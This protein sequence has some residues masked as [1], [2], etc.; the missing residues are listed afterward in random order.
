MEQDEEDGVIGCS[1][2]GR[3]FS[4]RLRLARLLLILPPAN[5]PL[6]TA[7]KD[8]PHYYQGIIVKSSY[9]QTYPEES[10]VVGSAEQPLHK[11]NMAPN[12][13]PSIHDTPLL[14]LWF[15]L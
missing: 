7:S 6:A 5:T 14:Q 2:P 10:T 4:S 3:G 13:Q 11:E 15:A 8:E 9:Q 1:W 12:L